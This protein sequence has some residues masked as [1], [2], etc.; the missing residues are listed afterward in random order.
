MI[1][2]SLPWTWNLNG[3]RKS[4][5][6]MCLSALPLAVNEE[7]NKRNWLCDQVP[8]SILSICQAD[9]GPLL[10]DTRCKP[11]SCRSAGEGRPRSFWVSDS[12]RNE[13]VVFYGAS[14]QRRCP[15]GWFVGCDF[16]M[17]R[18]FFVFHLDWL[19][20]CDSWSFIHNYHW[21]INTNVG[22]LRDTVAST[23]A[24][25]SSTVSDRWWEERRLFC[26]NERQRSR[27]QVDVTG[28]SV[29]TCRW[30]DDWV[31]RQGWASLPPLMYVC[32]LHHLF[33]YNGHSLLL[34]PLVLKGF[35]CNGTALCL[36]V[37]RGCC[38]IWFEASIY[39]RTFAAPSSQ[40]S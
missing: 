9:T 40:L 18:S 30:L 22:F 25:A 15:W 34:K 5:L 37:Q 14:S 13:G 33:D 10:I 7:S 31:R 8:S 32:H 12:V 24:N 20:V 2:I 29:G 19:C 39:S 17:W 38:C 28:A 36:F 1:K 16:G 23:K 6:Q 21:V 3:D 11:P 27:Q 26:C 35:G 4:E